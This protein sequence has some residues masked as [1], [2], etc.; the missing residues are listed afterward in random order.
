MKI[1]KLTELQQLIE[2]EKAKG[3][4]IIQC[5][6]VFDLL[7]IGHIRYFKQAKAMG[8]V[9]IVTITP[10]QFVDKGPH[11]PAFPENLRAEGI[12][13]LSFVDYVAINDWPTAE[14]TLRLLKPDVYVKG[15]EFK[16]IANDMI[17][18]IA[19]EAA[20]IK[21]IGAEIA[22]TE[23]IVFSS[24][25]LINRHLSNLP[26]EINQYLDLFR[27]RYT[28]EEIMDVI[29]RMAE[30]KVLVVGDTI[31][32]DYQYCEPIGKS[33]KD[34]VLTVKYQSHDIFAGGVLAIANHLANFCKSVDLVSNL[35][36]Q[37]SHEDF[38]RSQLNPKVSPRFSVQA[39]APT[40]IKRRFIDGYSLNKL[41][42]VYVMDDSYLPEKQDQQNCKW[43]EKKMADYDLVIAADFG[44]GAISPKMVDTLCSHAP[45]LAVNTQANSGNRGFH[46]ITR[47]SRADY[48]SLAEHEIRL[49]MRDRTNSIRPMMEQL[50]A[51]LDISNFVIT[52][53]RRGCLILG[54]Q[55]NFVEIPSF[56]QNV[57]D[58]VGAG[59]SFFAIS[60]LAAKLRVSDELIGFIGN[61]AG[62]LAVA[63][64]GNEKSIDKISMKKYITSLIK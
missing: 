18:K 50:A 55:E 22:F 14:E 52:R 61:L 59:D 24:T 27:Q 5:H 47:Y 32:D 19:G 10:D 11:R 3:K 38:I 20:V 34:P 45:F 4:K 26:E 7:H 42:E 12:A 2:K 16:D 56:A 17:G 6:G 33:S 23:D 21:E 48:V 43:L 39:N 64:L 15:A 31:I 63:I 35:G 9:L 41:F 60:A 51:Q 37:N 58:R 46:T 30:L 49:E 62:G 44:H 36:E 28:T 53:G 13:S 40:L 25:N 8:D 54:D 1:K 57:V 29:D